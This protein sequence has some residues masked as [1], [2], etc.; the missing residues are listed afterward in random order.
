MPLGNEVRSDCYPQNDMLSFV[1]VLSGNILGLTLEGRELP[2]T[3]PT[4]RLKTMFMGHAMCRRNVRRERKESSE[5]PTRP[6]TKKYWSAA[7][8]R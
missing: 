6:V 5:R 7:V 3:F 1:L 8:E 4:A 2:D